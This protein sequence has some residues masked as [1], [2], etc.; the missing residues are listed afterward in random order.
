MFILKKAITS[1]L[2]FPGLIIIAFTLLSIISLIKKQKF[3]SILILTLS[4]LM[5]LFSTSIV[6]DSMMNSIEMEGYHIDEYNDCDCIIILGGGITEDVVDLTGNE[7]LNQFS[8][9]RLLGGM[10]IHNKYKLPIIV[11]GGIINGKVSE[12]Q[13]LKRILIEFNI[14]EE[15]IIIE[16]KSKDT[17]QNV[18]NIKDI[19]ENNNFK[20][21]A[22]VTSSFH[23]R[24]AA[25]LF[26]YNNI[27][28]KPVPVNQKGKKVKFSIYRILPGSGS[29]HDSSLVI[30]EMLGLFFYKMML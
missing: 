19:I 20:K 30:K 12:A 23:M 22:L 1:F 11:T 14:N 13:V 6:S 21:C 24:R 3:I 28:F 17:R 16:D 8:N 15:M 25:Y 9:A 10:R 2:T 5:Y 26:K 4:I 29:L 7:S 27:D 18:E